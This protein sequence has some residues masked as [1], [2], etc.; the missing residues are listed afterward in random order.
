MK[1]ED[2]DEK[3]E[4]CWIER[5]HHRKVALRYRSKKVIQRQVRCEARGSARSDEVRVVR[6]RPR[7]DDDDDDDLTSAQ[8]AAAWP[9]TSSRSNPTTS[10]T[11]ATSRDAAA[12]SSMRRCLPWVEGACQ[13]VCGDANR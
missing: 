13:S 7:A 1:D 11:S 5:G 6:R 9:S 8:T 12:C 3:V 4:E 2:D 10:V